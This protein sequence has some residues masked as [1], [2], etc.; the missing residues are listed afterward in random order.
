LND[1][2]RC[3]ES[4]NIEGISSES[5]VFIVG[6]ILKLVCRTIIARREELESTRCKYVAVAIVFMSKKKKKRTI[7]DQLSSFF[8]D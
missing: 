3:I 2:F 8:F 7:D 6:F 5:K 4:D 1:D